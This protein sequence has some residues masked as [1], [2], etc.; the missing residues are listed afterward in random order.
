MLHDWSHNAGLAAVF[1]GAGGAGA[2]SAGHSA[3][4]VE[5]SHAWVAARAAR[6][7]TEEWFVTT[8]QHGVQ[9]HAASLE[10][11]LAERL[12]EVR[13]AS[14]SRIAGSMR[15][16]L[17]TTVAALRYEVHP[18][19]VVWQVLWAGDS[20]CYLLDSEHGLQQVSRDDAESGDALVLLT[21]DPPMTNMVSANRRFTIHAAPGHAAIPCLLVCATDG[22]FGYLNTPAEFEFLLLDTMANA[23]DLTD[24]STLLTQTV[25][26]YTGDDASLALVALGFDDF[27][28]LRADFEWRRSALQAEHIEP[29]RRASDGDRES[30]VAARMESWKLYRGS[31]EQR[32]P[33]QHGQE[34]P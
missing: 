10:Q 18:D 12:G 6:G 19:R 20:R 15:R 9:D 33:R 11:H 8:G 3:Q 4:G 13:G 32:M 24:W 25:S 30:F 17:P 29:T 21:E 2:A 16:D 34:R 26:S 28:Q 31:Y 1:D 23:A 22:F 27:D 7:L 5:R 14:R